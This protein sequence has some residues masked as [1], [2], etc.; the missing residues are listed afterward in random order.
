MKKF[1]PF[2]LLGVGLV[3]L[4]VTFFVIKKLRQPKPQVEEEETVLMDVELKDRPIVSLTPSTD[5]HY[6][7][8]KIEKIKIPA[9]SLDYELIYQT[10]EITQGVPGE[11]QIQ[12]GQPFEANILLGSESSG[13]FRYDQGVETGS[14]NLRFRKD[15]KLIARFTT[16]FHLQTNTD[17]LTSNDNEFTYDGVDSVTT[18]PFGIFTSAES[19]P[20]GEA[21]DS[22]WQKSSDNVFYK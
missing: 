17:T 1:L 8:L 10:S 20:S 18:G 19:L 11:V 2:I 6:L 7:K 15:G 4:V 21:A 16:D 14:V 13:K 9:T 3:V 5:G 22:S 12:E